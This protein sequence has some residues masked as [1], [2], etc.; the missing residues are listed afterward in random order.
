[1]AAA[2]SLFTI[3]FLSV[4]FARIGSVALR[5]TGLPVHV[6]Q[7]QARSAFSGTGF[8]T[9]EANLVVNHPDRRRVISI[10]MVLGNAGI[11]STVSAIVLSYADFEATQ[12]NL[13]E[14]AIWLAGLV[15]AIWF[16]AFSKFVE[17]QMTRVIHYVLEHTT[18]LAS[19]GVTSLLSLGDGYDVLVVDI[20]IG[21]SLDGRIFEEV[22]NS[23]I[24]G[25]PLAIFHRD[26]TLLAD[27][28]DDTRLVAGDSL[29][30][31]GRPSEIADR[32]VS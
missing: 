16:V 21:S 25:V 5:L 32:C 27:P 28:D 31:Y 8:T 17:H 26:G 10:L 12:E 3:V 6:A 15:L 22:K 18:H 20:G 11:V 7:F 9:D 23:G 29:V 1:M 14:E 13:I 4:V 24:T 30:V 19:D 2:L